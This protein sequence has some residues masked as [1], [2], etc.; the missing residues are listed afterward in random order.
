MLSR[1]LDPGSVRNDANLERHL[2]RC[3]GCAAA[4]RAERE[5]TSW[6]TARPA[7]GPPAVD[8]TAR[9]MRTLQQQTPPA[10]AEV[11]ASQL[12]WASACAAAA[13]I[14]LALSVNWIRPELSGVAVACWELLGSLRPVGAQVISLAASLVAI[15]VKLS[16]DLLAGLAPLGSILQRVQPL[17]AAAVTLAVAAMTGSIVFIVGRDLRSPRLAQEES[18]E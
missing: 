16:G 3:P 2:E 13:A 6:L 5:L 4:D 14:A 18:P 10:R 1:E 7:G 17:A 15:P 12:A 11:G 9:V 8:V